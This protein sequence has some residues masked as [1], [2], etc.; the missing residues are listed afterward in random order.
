MAEAAEAAAA[1]ATAGPLPATAEAAAAEAQQQAAPPLLRRPGCRR[2]HPSRCRCRGVPGVSA[3]TLAN[4]AASL[5]WC[6]ISIF[7]SNCVGSRA[8][9]RSFG[10]IGLHM[11]Q[12]EGVPILRS[13]ERTSACS[14]ESSGTG[15]GLRCLP[16]ASLLRCPRRLRG[17]RPLPPSVGRR[18]RP[19]SCPPS[20]L[21]VWSHHHSLQIHRQQRCS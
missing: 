2:R 18:L 19:S 21:G 9:D 16:P 17:R 7:T 10:K 14:S 5:S 6:G 4:T 11:S 12:R 1:T 20:P 8:H 15:G 3:A 13:L